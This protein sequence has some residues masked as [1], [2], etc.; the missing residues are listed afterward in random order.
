MKKLDFKTLVISGLVMLLIVSGF[1]HV[2]QTDIVEAYRMEKER[3]E[4]RLQHNDDSLRSVIRE[5]Q[6]A[7][8]RALQVI[9]EAT[10]RADRAENQLTI[11]NE[12]LKKVRF[13]RFPND[14]V[15][16]GAISELYHSYK[17]P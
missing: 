17:R 8:L 16:S 2:E 6:A 14:S 1:F 10:I 11:A 13:V 9:Q 12:K 7:D 15:R 5:F 4:K 3:A